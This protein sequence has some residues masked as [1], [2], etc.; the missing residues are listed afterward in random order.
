MSDLKAKL[1]LSKTNKKKCKF[2]NQLNYIQPEC[3]SKEGITMVKMQSKDLMEENPKLI[4]VKKN[5]L[6]MLVDEREDQ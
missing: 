5:Q 2:C 1:E 6:E 3:E 4:C